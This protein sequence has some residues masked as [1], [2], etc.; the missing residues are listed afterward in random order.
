MTLRVGVYRQG[1]VLDSH[2]ANHR[3]HPNPLR[4]QIVENP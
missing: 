3:G 2:Q 4:R 1:T